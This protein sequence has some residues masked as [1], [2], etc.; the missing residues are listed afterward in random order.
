MIPVAGVVIPLAGQQV[1]VTHGHTV[2]LRGQI[3]TM[4]LRR[5]RSGKIRPAD[6]TRRSHRSSDVVGL[7]IVPVGVEH[8]ADPV[9]PGV[10]V[11]HKDVGQADPRREQQLP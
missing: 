7:L 6:E 10:L 1:V 9:A 8:R 5:R 4:R 11:L 3:Q 2:F